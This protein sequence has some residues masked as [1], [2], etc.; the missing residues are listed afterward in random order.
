MQR[1]TDLLADP[2]GGKAHSLTGSARMSPRKGPTTA[3]SAAAIANYILA[4]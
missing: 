4:A 3:G 2:A 1:V